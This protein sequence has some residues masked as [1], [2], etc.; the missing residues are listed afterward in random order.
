MNYICP[1]CKGKITIV[2]E[3]ICPECGYK[4][5]PETLD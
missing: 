3:L 5:N 4:L 2:D 1:K